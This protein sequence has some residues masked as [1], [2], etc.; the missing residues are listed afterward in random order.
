MKSRIWKPV[1]YA[2]Y[3][4]TL[5]LELWGWSRSLP[6]Y[7]CFTYIYQITIVLTQNYRLIIQYDLALL[8]LCIKRNYTF[9]TKVANEK[10]LYSLPLNSKRI[11]N[12]FFRYLYA[13]KWIIVQPILKQLHLFL[14]SF[15]T[16]LMIHM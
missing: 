13:K 11:A 9:F 6:L 16:S 4:S 8:F 2:S 5:C 14:F 3:M 10:I 1:S 15:Y 7:N 12:I